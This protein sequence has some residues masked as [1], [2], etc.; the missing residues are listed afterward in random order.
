MIQTLG[1]AF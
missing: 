1:A